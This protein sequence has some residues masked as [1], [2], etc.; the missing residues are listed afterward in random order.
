M[1]SAPGYSGNTTGKGGG[2]PNATQQQKEFYAY[3]PVGNRLSSDKTKTYV[4]NQ[5]NQLIINGGT[6][7]YDKN[8]NLIQKVTADGTTAYA[9]DYENRLVKVTTPYGTVAEFAY[10]PFGKRIQKRVTQSGT[11]T[12]TKYF[13]DNQNIILEHDGAG[14]VVNKYVHGSGVDE[15]LAVT[16]GENTFF[17]HADGLGSIVA[18]TD[19]AGKV[20]QTYDYDSF[21]NLKDQKNRVK[22]PYAYTGREWDKEIGL[23]FNRG[24]YF[25]PMEGR[26][27]SKDPIGF[28]GG[29]NV[30]VYVQNNPINAIDPSGLQLVSLQEGRNIVNI[31]RLWIGIVYRSGGSNEFGIDCSHLVWRVYDEAGFPYSYRTT[32]GFPPSGKFQQVTNPQ[33]GD[34]VLYNGHM[35][36][37][38]N[39]QLISA[40]SGLGRVDY[41]PLGWYGPIRGY[42]RYDK[43]ND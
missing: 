23:Y 9:W 8:G 40:R 20:V 39:G 42:F 5:G 10:D 36:I 34:V 38:T 19:S 26:F 18:L 27:I 7:S 6:F 15:A 41:S 32:G 16:T 12:V 30:Y 25:D 14:T 43:C 29:I 35:G 37:Y 33:E 22:Q 2:I 28:E 24:R 3:D 1:S 17:Y 4:Y 11:A 21:G 31:A 13:Y